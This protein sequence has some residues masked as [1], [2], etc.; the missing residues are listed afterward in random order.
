MNFHAAKPLSAVDPEFGKVEK[1]EA[2]EVQP[3]KNAK[4]AL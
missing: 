1:I 2:V 4:D 3:T